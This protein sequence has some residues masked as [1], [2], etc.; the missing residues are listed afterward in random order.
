MIG[1]SFGRWT[2]LAESERRVTGKRQWLCRCD[3]GTERH[4]TGSNLRNGISRSCGCYKR[5]RIH[6]AKYRHGR[7][8]SDRTY[9][10]WSS[11]RNRCTNS[12][13]ARYARY[14]GRGICVCARW[15]SFETFLADMGD[16]PPGMSIERIDNDG[17]YE[18]SNC[19]WATAM[20]Q[21]LNKSTTRYVVAFGHR[22]PLKAW[23]DQYGLPFLLVWKRL[24][25]GW[26]P[27]RALM[28]PAQ[29]NGAKDRRSA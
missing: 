8:S 6:L 3:C 10:A 19:R 16:C 26:L 20:E 9:S 21:S 5:E 12:R 15:Q 28:T 25:R 17:N 22:Q 18:P 29:P 27:E 23:T 2:V 14:G 1:L 7:G 13:C 11:M 4:I 24:S